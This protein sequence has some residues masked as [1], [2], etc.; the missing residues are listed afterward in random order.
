MN[1][2]LFK[3]HLKNS[4]IISRRV[5]ILSQ[6]LYLQQLSSTNKKKYSS[7]Q[8]LGNRNFKY[9]LIKYKLEF[10]PSIESSEIEHNYLQEFNSLETN[11][12]NLSRFLTEYFKF[13]KA[14]HVKNGLNVS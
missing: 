14:S 10:T 4:E 13:K 3:D 11:S 8:S 6:I 9:F 5:S 2:Q 12:P 1:S 7:L